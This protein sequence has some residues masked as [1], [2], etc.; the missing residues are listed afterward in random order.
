MR[1]LAIVLALLCG[2]C[3]TWEG[4]NFGLSVAN[5]DTTLTITQGDGKTVLSA[6]QDG[7]KI[8]GHFRR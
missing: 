5:A 3:A 7:Q 1:H 6:E 2:G 8:S 4:V